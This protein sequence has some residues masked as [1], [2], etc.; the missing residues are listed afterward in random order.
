MIE[1]KNGEMVEIKSDCIILDG[2]VCASD[3]H[4]FCTRGIYSYWRE[5]WLERIDA[6]EDHVPDGP[7]RG[8][9]L[10]PRLILLD[11]A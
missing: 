8:L 6:T 11:I 10:E 3:F 7:V 2:V 4:L 9:A 1:E 5:I